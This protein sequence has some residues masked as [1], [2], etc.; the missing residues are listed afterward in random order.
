MA[1]RVVFN[2]EGYKNLTKDGKATGF[3][4]EMKL[5]YYRGITLSIIRD[6]KVSIDGREIPR[7][8]IRVVINGE[9]FTLEQCR[10]V[11]SPLFRWEFG[12]Y[13]TVEVDDE[14]GL[15]AGKHHIEV[16]QHIAPS[17]M[18]FPIMANV[19]DDFEI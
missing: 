13:G 6:I 18:P 11:V 14:G 5:Q 3:S 15:A 9:K 1:G 2:P 7:E 4:F 10:T 8:N 16:L 17:Y 19:A 12:T